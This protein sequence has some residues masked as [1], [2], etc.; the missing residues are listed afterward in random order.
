MP[1]FDQFSKTFIYLFDF[2]FLVFCAHRKLYSEVNYPTHT[3][4]EHV[5]PIILTSCYA[6]HI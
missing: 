4:G 6:S 5:M 2:V 3:C 1:V